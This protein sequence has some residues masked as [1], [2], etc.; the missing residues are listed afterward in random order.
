MAAALSS[1]VPVVTITGRHDLMT[2]I[3]DVRLTIQILSKLIVES[4][5]VDGGHLVFSVGKN[6]SFIFENVLPNLK[7]YNTA[8]KFEFNKVVSYYFI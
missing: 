7:K 6:A 3:E 5:E 8:W 1:K 4:K 2:K